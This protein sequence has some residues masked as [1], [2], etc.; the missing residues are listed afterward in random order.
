MALLQN[1]PERRDLAEEI[2]REDIAE[3][4]IHRTAR[5]KF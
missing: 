2:E 5:V 3:M 1:T 4:R